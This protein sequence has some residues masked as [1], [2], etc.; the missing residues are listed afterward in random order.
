MPTITIDIRE[1]GREASNILDTIANKGK[2]ISFSNFKIGFVFFFVLFFT[3]IALLFSGALIFIGV[4]LFIPF[5]AVSILA[6]SIMPIVMAGVA[7][8]YLLYSRAGV[9]I[10]SLAL[11]IC[12]CISFFIIPYIGF[13]LL[14]VLFIYCFGIICEYIYKG[15]LKYIGNVA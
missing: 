6:S 5:V 10:K 11:G 3:S 12:F 7:N 9:S 13:I 4:I 14:I 1:A 2:D 8:E 15:H